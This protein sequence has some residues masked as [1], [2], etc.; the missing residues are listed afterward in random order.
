M[1]TVELDFIAKMAQEQKAK[2]RF[3]LFDVHITVDQNLFFATSC[4]VFWVG[5]HVCCTT[6]LRAERVVY[7]LHRRLLIMINNSF[8]RERV[9]Y[10]FNERFV[11][12]RAGDIISLT[13]SSE[14]F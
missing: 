14:R 11:S 3:L 9:F 13:R 10:H 7:Q 1:Q 6:L 4:S 2:V 5:R 12:N 8:V